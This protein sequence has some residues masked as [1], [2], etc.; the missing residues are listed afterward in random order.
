MIIPRATYRVQFHQ[1][2][3]FSDAIRIVPYLAKL[4]VSHLYASP[5]TV[6]RP[7]SPHGYDVVDPTRLNPEL[8][9]GEDFDRLTAA[10]AS[11]DMGLLLDIVP[12]HMPASVDNPWWRDVLTNGQA[13]RYADFFDV[14]WKSEGGKIVLPMLGHSLDQAIADGDISYDGASLIAGGVRLPL[15]PGTRGGVVRSVLDQQHYRLSS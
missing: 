10:L 8:G 9:S 7:G 13:S 15:A 14:D 5:L 2:F 3:G 4:G 1:G 11:H 6:A 12:N